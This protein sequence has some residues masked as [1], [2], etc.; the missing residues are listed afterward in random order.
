MER[1]H[2]SES[3]A[4]LVA[5][6]LQGEQDSYSLLLQRHRDSVFRIALNNINDPDEALDITQE[7]FV[8]AFASLRRYDPARPFRAWIASITINKCRDWARRR[9]V[10]QFL[11]FAKPIEGAFDVVSEDRNPEE[12][13]VASEEIAEMR[14][15]L[16]SLPEK[17]RTPVI[18]CLVEGM[19]Q[20]EAASALGVNRKTV[21]TRIYRARKLLAEAIEG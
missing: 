18:L 15:A 5:R 3:D 17:L 4:A 10:R 14:T 12:Q 6:A 20:D 13:A 11:F 2:S 1:E 21:E 9:K 19:S 16:A 7:S 8:S